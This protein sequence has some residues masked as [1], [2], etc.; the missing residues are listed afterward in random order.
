MEIRVNENGTIIIG[1]YKKIGIT[2]NYIILEL[3]LCNLG[4][5]QSFVPNHEVLVY[6]KICF[7]IL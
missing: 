2:F 6:C 1:Y 7:E 3:T 4:L 5:I